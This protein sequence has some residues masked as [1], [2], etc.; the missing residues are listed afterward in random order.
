MSVHTSGTTGVPKKVAYSDKNIS[1]AVDEYSR[2]YNFSQ[3][4]SILFSLP[5]HYCYSVIPCC[6]VP[7]ALGKKVILAPS[8]ST[9]IDIARLIE[10]E[11]VHILVVNPVFYIA[12][13]RLDLCQ[14]D[15]SSLQLCDSGG[16]SIPPSVV[17]MLYKQANTLITEGYGLTETTSLTHFLLPDSRGQIRI[18]SVGRACSDVKTRLLD[19]LGDEVENG[20]IGELW[21][22]GPMVADGVE[23]ELMDG[24]NWL[25]TEDLFY[26]DSDGFFYFV[27]RKKDA[28]I[29]DSEFVFVAFQAVQ[30][31]VNLDNIKDVT[32]VVN[33]PGD[34]TIF[35]SLIDSMSARDRETYGKHIQDLLPISIRDSAT[36]R[37]VDRIPRTVTGKVKKG[38]L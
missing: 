28:P 19:T 10:K 25:N 5:F 30:K 17:D 2:V 4:D 38:D 9:P 26:E 23:T 24:E 37:Y 6:I 12:L 21:V 32:H 3:K 29:E 11:K 36:I 15:L 16:E 13:S 34:I 35:V 1:W 20:E 14:F 27:S 22:S 18:G 7:F 33:G 8:D 31:L